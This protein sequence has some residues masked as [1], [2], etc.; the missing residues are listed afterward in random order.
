MAEIIKIRRVSPTAIEVTAAGDYDDRTLT[1]LI[2]N[3]ALNG[4]PR[5][6]CL[7]QAREN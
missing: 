1:Y 2:E 6:S 7:Q 4:G 5:I 3:I